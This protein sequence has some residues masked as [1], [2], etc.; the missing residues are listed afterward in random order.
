MIKI[1]QLRDEGDGVTRLRVEGRI[2]AKTTESLER[3][4][5]AGLAGPWP[6]LL[7]VSGVSFVDGDGA[8][9]LTALVARGVVVI[10]ASTFVGE[11]L[12]TATVEPGGE[13]S[14]T[15]TED[16]DAM[17]VARLRSGDDDAFDEMTRQY[18]GRM[19]AVARRM[20]RTEDDAHDAVQE[21]FLSAFKSLDRFEGHSK[22]STWLHRIVV[23]AAL[24]RLRT[25]KRKP[26]ASIDDLLPSFDETGHFAAEVSPPDLPSDAFERRELRTVVRQC[27]DRLPDSYRA[28]VLLRDIEELDADETATAL[29]ITTSAVKSRLHRARQALHALLTEARLGDASAAEPAGRDRLRGA[30]SHDRG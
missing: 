13:P 14:G 12:R 17:L 26:E 30:A 3:A 21:A 4:C 2:L 29:G 22:L 25:R 27:I 6:V 9:M 18:A 16:P 19:L 7:D 28:V 10:G 20:L 15:A 1:T 8:A 23:N 5:V 11:I 24:M